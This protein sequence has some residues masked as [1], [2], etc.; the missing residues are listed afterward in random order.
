MGFTRD[1]A[2]QSGLF[3][4]SGRLAFAHC[5]GDSG[6]LEIG[7]DLS[8]AWD[9]CGIRFEP[10]GER[11]ASTAKR[12]TRETKR[13]RAL[14]PRNTRIFSETARDAPEL[15]GRP[16]RRSECARMSLRKNAARCRRERRN[17]R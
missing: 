10:E 4:Q 16:N 5:R 15:A 14:N 11:T 9:A 2:R 17:A 12:F 8:G 13:F 3:A 6:Q 1:G 7:R